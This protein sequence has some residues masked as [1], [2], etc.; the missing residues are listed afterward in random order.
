MNNFNDY[1]RS[2]SEQEKEWLLFLL[3]ED[4]SGYKSYRDIIN[5]MVIIEEGRFGEGNYVLG[6]EGDEPDLSYSSLPVFASGQIIFKECTVQTTIHELY[7]NKIEISINNVSGYEIPDT[8]TELKRWTYSTWSPGSDSPFE[9]DKL[10]EVNLTSGRE[11]D[12][13]VFSISMRTIWLYEPVSQVNHIIPVTNFLNELLR[14][15]T[16]IDRTKGVNINFIFEKL[17]LFSDDEIIKAFVQ[18]NKQYHKVNLLDTDLRKTKKKGI[19]GKF[20]K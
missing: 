16:K 19:F 14:G 13:L 18:Y 6:F 7:E 9:S 8:L 20:L 2:L 4:R 3:P 1:P 10:R 11:N 17:N 5:K 15:N 12:V